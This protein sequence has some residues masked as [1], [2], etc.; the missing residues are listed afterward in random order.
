MKLINLYNVVVFFTVTPA[1]KLSQVSLVRCENCHVDIP[2]NRYQYH[3]RTNLHK[4]NCLLN[5]KYNNIEVISTAFKNRIISY[6]LSPFEEYLTPESFL[7]DNEKYVIKIINNSLKRFQS[8]KLNFELFVFFYL[9]KTG[10]KQLKSFNT[11][12]SIISKGTDVHELYLKTINT[13]EKK[14]SEFQHRESGWTC[15]SMSHL[16]ININKYSPFRGGSYIALPNVVKNTKSCINIRNNDNHCFLWSIVAALFPQNNNVCRTSSYPHYSEVLNIDGNMSFPPSYKDIKMFE[17]INEL[18]INVYGLDNKHNVTGPLYI[19][20][21]RKSNHINLLYIQKNGKGHY[22]LIKNL[23]KL[24]KRQVTNHTSNMYLCELCLQTFTSKTKYTSHNCNE[25]LTELPAKNSYLQF[26]NY[27]RQQ[28]INFIIYADFESIL[29]KC[30]ENK[31]ENTR[32]YEMH[33]PSCFGY[34]ICCSHDPKLNKYVTYKGSDC[35]QVFM[36]SSVLNWFINHLPFELHLPGY[37]YCGPGTKS[38]KKKGIN[39]LDEYC[40]EH[41][42]AYQQSSDLSDRHKADIKLMNMARN[43]ITASDASLE[44]KIA[45]KNK[46]MIAK[47][48][49]GAGLGINKAAKDISGGGLKKQLKYIISHTNKHLK[50]LK[51]KGKNMAIKLAMAAAKELATNTTVKVSDRERLTLLKILEKDKPIQLAFR[52]WDL[53]EYAFL[54]R[55]TKHSWA[56]KTVSQ[57]EKPRYHRPSSVQACMEV[58]ETPTHVFLE[59][60]GVAKQRKRHLGSPTSLDEALGDLGGLLGFWSELGWLE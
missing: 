40:K 13:F 48:K 59:C 17:K 45:D 7:I 39:Q 57:L 46:A 23:L 19:T 56:V 3:L 54:P 12:Y 60:T 15:E 20:T 34:Y 47:V 8:V 35:V 55:T 28:K 16:E 50:K 27:E 24:V 41:D 4:S 26:K 2:E 10:E 29:M 33:Q 1:S 22:C 32:L 58:D 38:Y 6:K 30:N 11:K 42:I 53:Y 21:A 44:E 43:R 14:I 25:I 5:T 52:N 37:N 31:S 36:C 9:S 49:Y 51:P 18:S